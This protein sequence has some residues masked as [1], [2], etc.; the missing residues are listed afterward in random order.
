MRLPISIAVA[1]LLL[2]SSSWAEAWQRYANAEDANR[3]YDPYRKVVMSG[4]AFI[5]D[6]HE[7]Q[8]EGSEG[9]RA[10]RRR[11]RCAGTRCVSGVFRA[12]EHQRKHGAAAGALR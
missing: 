6:L 9:G 3:Y 4:I 7:L 12:I 5:W 2:S 1:C 11:P 10:R 8:A